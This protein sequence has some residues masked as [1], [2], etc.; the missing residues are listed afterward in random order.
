M[1][2]GVACLAMLLSVSYED[3]LLAMGRYT[4]AYIREVKAAA[5]RLKKPLRFT[6]K[7]DLENDTGILAV[8]SEK[9]R[10]D[11]LVVLKDGLIVDTDGSIWD[12]DVFMSA[13]VATGLS[14]LVY[15]GKD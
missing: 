11:H 3:A 9:W 8:K 15:D 13:N 7:F 10:T 1:D 14:L 12:H 5:K 6:R 2:C 4:G